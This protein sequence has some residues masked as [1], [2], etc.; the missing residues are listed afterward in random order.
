MIDKC[1][2][3]NPGRD[4]QYMVRPDT[5]PELLAIKKDLDETLKKIHN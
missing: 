3:T 4:T 2:E 1:I 5:Q